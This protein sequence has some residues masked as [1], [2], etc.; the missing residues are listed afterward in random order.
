MKAR[1]P[2]LVIDIITIFPEYFTPALEVGN[3]KK[4]I[5]NGIVEVRFHDL[6]KLADSPKEIDDYPFGGG[7]GMVLK[8]EPLKRALE[9]A[10]YKKGFVINFSPQGERLTQSLAHRLIEKKHLILICGRYKGIDERIIDRYVDMEI[11]IGD[12]VLSGGEV[13]ALVLLDVL[14]R[15]LPGVL[16]D[17]D[18]AMTDSFETGL[19]DT[20]YYTRPYEF[21]GETVPE[22]LISGNHA[23]IRRWRRKESLRKTLKYRPELLR[24]IFLTAEDM[25][26]L[27]EID[28][29]M[30][31]DLRK[32]PEGE[33]LM[34]DKEKGGTS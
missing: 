24:K 4:A 10:D 29:D 32:A 8:P 19:L 28:K 1:D 26:I 2:L 15:L 6:K 16:H 7:P 5:E 20:S 31:N 12:Y 18:S 34:Q 14:V 23:A 22:V 13:A 17:M 3:L 30:D 11:S 21:E 25:D 33:P 27:G 9:K